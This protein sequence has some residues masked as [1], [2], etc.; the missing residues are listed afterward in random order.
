M[1]S[2]ICPNCGCVGRVPERFISGSSTA[3]C[4]MCGTEIYLYD[5]DVDP[6]EFPGQKKGDSEQ[7]G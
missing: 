6:F 4:E 1:K 7:I 3:K 5:G 2:Q